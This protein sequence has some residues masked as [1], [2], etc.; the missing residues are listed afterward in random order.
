MPVINDINFIWRAESMKTNLSFMAF[1]AAFALSLTV[2]GA[3]D[4]YLLCKG[5]MQGIIE[6]SCDRA[7][8]EG[9]IVVNAVNHAVYTPRDPATG[10]G[11]GKI[12]HQP[13]RFTKEVDKASPKLMQ[14]LLTNERLSMFE[15]GYWRVS[16]EGT[17]LEAYRIELKGA[18]I[19]SINQ[20]MLHNKMD[21]FVQLMRAGTR[22]RGL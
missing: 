8:R 2:Y 5:E 22:H 16:P 6:G 20:E 1:T 19:I 11:S 7:G 13:L 10:L 3:S 17:E 14:A 21:E 18:R 9:L 4:A 12:T 15:L